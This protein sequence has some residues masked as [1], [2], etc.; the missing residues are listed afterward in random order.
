MTGRLRRALVAVLLFWSPAA[1]AADRPGEFDFYVLAL[2][3][4]PSY[5]AA[6]G[7]S[8]A[9][10]QCGRGAG[11]GFVVHGL[12]PQYERGYPESCPTEQPLQVPRSR[13]AAMLD[14]MPDPDLVGRQW[15][16]HGT[17]SGL[18]QQAYFDLVRAARERVVI[19]ASLA[20]APRFVSAREAETAFVAANPGLPEGGI[21]A[22]CRDG[23]LTEI[24]LCLSRDLQFRRCREVDE[25][26]CRQ[27]RLS[28]PEPR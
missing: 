20:A 9:S 22:V 26:G 16:K 4:S 6:A 23:R 7:R 5:C 25:R 18:D 28:L 19:P 17:C 11:H 10:P 2:S 27:R 21:A 3:W 13:I 12:W 24:R 14:L 1:A 8:A 15:R